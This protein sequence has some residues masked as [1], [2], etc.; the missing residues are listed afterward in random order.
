MQLLPPMEVVWKSEKFMS[1][2]DASFRTAN[3]SDVP[4]SSVTIPP[5]STIAM[6]MVLEWSVADSAAAGIFVLSSLLNEIRLVCSC[7][8]S[9]LEVGPLWEDV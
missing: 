8:P 9:V 4:T 3:K 6:D 2:D 7:L 5:P 1:L